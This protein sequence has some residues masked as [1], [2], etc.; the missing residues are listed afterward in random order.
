MGV[1]GNIT[2]D[3]VDVAD[4]ARLLALALLSVSLQQ[5]PTDPC[6]VQYPI[7]CIQGLG[8]QPVADSTEYHFTFHRQL[9]RM[10]GSPPA[11]RNKALP[12]PQDARRAEQLRR[13]AEV[14][15]RAE[16]VLCA[17]EHCRL[18]R[19]A[20]SSQFEV[21]YHPGERRKEQHIAMPWARKSTYD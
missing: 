17:V 9:T 10:T 20:L 15:E 16:A 8:P 21:G 19:G 1:V 6:K 13:G 5:L 11:A 14:C 4:H 3:H 12:S 2:S 18:L 7:G